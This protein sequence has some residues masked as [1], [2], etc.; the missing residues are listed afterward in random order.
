ME[1]RNIIIEKCIYAGFKSFREYY[2]LG[3]KIGYG[4]TEIEA[5]EDLLFMEDSK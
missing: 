1:I 2:D 5:L 4:K 3:D